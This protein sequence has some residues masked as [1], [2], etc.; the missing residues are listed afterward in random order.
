MYLH[1]GK[2]MGKPV[3]YLMTYKFNLLEIM[4]GL[5]WTSIPTDGVVFLPEAMVV[6][7]H[8]TIRVM[9]KQK[10]VMTHNSGS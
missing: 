9:T 1:N 3:S 4:E 8:E 2:C 5:L 7:V 6:F 10:L